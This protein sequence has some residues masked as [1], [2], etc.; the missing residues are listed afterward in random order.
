MEPFF[1][2]T[3]VT[4][5]V[6]AILNIILFF[7]I[8]AMTNNVRYILNYLLQ[9]DGMEMTDNPSQ[10]RYDAEDKIFVPKN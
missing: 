8:W 6:F 5:L 3:S 1:L 4:L 9:R 2:A 7:K 10:Y